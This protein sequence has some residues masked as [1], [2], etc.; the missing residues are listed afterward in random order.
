[1]G[2]VGLRVVAV[3]ESE[4]GQLISALQKQLESSLTRPDGIMTMLMQLDIDRDGSLQPAETPPPLSQ[5]FG[6]LDG[7]N[8]GSLAPNELELV[9]QMAIGLS[10]FRTRVKD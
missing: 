9:K 1:M 8:D 10:S 7:N 5:W 4:R 6:L 2:L 3:N